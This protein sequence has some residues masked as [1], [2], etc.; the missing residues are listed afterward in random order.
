MYSNSED[1]AKYMDAVLKEAKHYARKLLHDWK[2]GRCNEDVLIF[3]SR[4]DSVVCIIRISVL[5]LLIINLELDK[6]F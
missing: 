6:Y 1:Q 2:M 3:F 5:H 4:N